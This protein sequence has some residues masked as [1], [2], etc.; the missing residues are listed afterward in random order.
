M[1]YPI[2]L[3]FVGD[4]CL[5]DDY[6]ASVLKNKNPFIH[7]KHF[8]EDSDLVIGNLEAVMAGNQGENLLK[9]TRLQIDYSS[10]KLLKYIYLNIITLAN[11]HI[12]D[13]LLEGFQRTI[14]FLRQ[15][16][17]DYLGAFEKGVEDKTVCMKTLKEKRFVFLN[18]VHPDTNP[19]L[20]EN[21]PVHLNL[22][23]KSIIVSE[24]KK[25]RSLADFVIL[26]L[27]WGMD[28]SR[29]PSPDQRN[30]AR[31]FIVAGAD[32]IIGHHSHVLQG[33]E[34]IGKAWIFYGLG[35]FAFSRRYENGEYN[36]L[37]N[38]RQIE[39]VILN[40]TINQN[41]F[42]FFWN[43]VCLKGVNV[44]PLTSVR[45][46]YLSTLLPIISNKIAWPFYVFYLNI[47]YKSFFFF[48]GNGRNPVQQFKSIDRKKIKRAFQLLFFK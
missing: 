16:E 30:D 19:L 10:L 26:L 6:S 44:M 11:N 45:M 5:N 39:S 21:C 35:N 1:I 43:P 24:I 34:R 40:M 33:Y 8:L 13:N 37:D 20:P 15:N 23:D 17:I 9:Q 27:H 3:S 48:F 28:N 7:V 42:E 31:A 4:I 14:S 2:Q 38:M 46:N 41:N 25:Y 32:V 36:D 47:I 22:Y 29:F 18:Y 12:Y